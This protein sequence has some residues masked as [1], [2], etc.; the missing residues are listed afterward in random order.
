MSDMQELK[1]ELDQIWQELH[2]KQ[3]RIKPAVAVTFLIWIVGSTVS[4]AWWAATTTAQLRALQQTVVESAK[5]QYSAGTAAQDF[6][7]RDQRLDFLQQQIDTHSN[8]DKEAH[9][10][11]RDQ[12]NAHEEKMRQLELKK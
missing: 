11:F 8:G 5:A 9:R 12:L 1:Q 6:R 3:D 2:A 7:L 4:G 10:Q